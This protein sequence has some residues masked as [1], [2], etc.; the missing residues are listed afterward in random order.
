LVSP[1]KRVAE[2]DVAAATLLNPKIA[3]SYAQYGVKP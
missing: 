3:D 1:L 2:A